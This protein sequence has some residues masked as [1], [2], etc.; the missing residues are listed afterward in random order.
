LGHG[1][2]PVDVVLPDDSAPVRQKG[3]KTP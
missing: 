3:R 2:E 1:G